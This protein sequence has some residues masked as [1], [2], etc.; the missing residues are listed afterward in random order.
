MAVGGT[1][2]V[3]VAARNAL[4]NRK[5]VSISSPLLQINVFFAFNSFVH[6]LAMTTLESPKEIPELGIFSL[7]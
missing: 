7:Q 6:S 2:T 3:L 1:V 5:R 4:N